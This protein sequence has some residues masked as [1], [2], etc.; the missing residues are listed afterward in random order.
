MHVEGNVRNRL[1]VVFVL[2]LA[3]R[4]TLFAQNA[5]QAAPPA[6]RGAAPAPA[7]PTPRYADGRPN[8]GTGPG[9]KGLWAGDGRL[10]VNP[11]SY[12][13]RSN[14][15]AP[16]HI[17]KVPLQPWARAL[18]D[19]RHENVLKH[20]PHPRCKASGG[21]R[22][23]I[24][25]YGIEIVDLPELRRV[26]VMDIGGPHSFKIVYMDRKE[27]PKNLEPSYYG[28]SIGRWE[29]DTLVIDTVG[30]NEK[31]W[32][33]RDGLPHTS[34]LHLIE[35]LTRLDSRT[36]KYE[37]TIDDPGAYTATWNSGFNMRWTDGLDLFEYVCQDNNQFPETA[38]G[39]EGGADP[40]AV[41]VVP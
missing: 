16:I 21:P 19:Y 13:P 12:E 31:F 1:M 33:N 8:L 37:V 27:H 29:G 17:D 9:E 14:Q 38:L 24:T 20:E 36:L 10:A 6:G 28:H 15:N 4:V 23:F 39:G 41:T 32:M 3:A 35:R 25:P 7:S 40:N 11:N 2:M 18:V 5:P 22:Q 26:Y 34:Q 30:F